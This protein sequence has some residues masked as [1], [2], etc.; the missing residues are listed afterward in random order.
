MEVEGSAWSASSSLLLVGFVFPVALTPIRTCDRSRNS[1]L[2][3]A[4]FL[5]EELQG[6]PN[7]SRRTRA[8][9]RSRLDTGQRPRSK[10]FFT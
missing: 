4:I 8:G 3:N 1:N 6:A 2:I 5:E 7:L 10:V 9:I